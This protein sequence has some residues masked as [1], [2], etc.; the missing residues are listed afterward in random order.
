MAHAQAASLQ[1]Q[2]ERLYAIETSARVEDF[3]VNTAQVESL[4]PA[5]ARTVRAAGEALLIAQSEDSLDLALYLQDDDFRA[6]TA[7]G[8]V[9]LDAVLRL[10]EGVSHFLYLAW[11]GSRNRQVSALELE[12]QA[13]VDK[14]VILVLAGFSDVQRLL[15]RLFGTPQL[16]SDLTTVERHRYRHAIRTAKRICT[17]LYQRY[18]REGRREDMVRSLRRFYRATR[19]DK[20]SARNV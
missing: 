5:L 9:P 18:L 17:E 1:R 8:P 16:R 20:L 7:S 2:L 11:H 14:F 15:H 4:A 13:E 3:V 19:A 12:V 10:L 6:L